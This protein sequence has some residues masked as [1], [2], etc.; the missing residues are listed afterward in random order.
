MDLSRRCSNW[1]GRS[2]PVSPSVMNIEGMLA[3]FDVEGLVLWPFCGV[4]YP[5]LGVHLLDLCLSSNSL[6]RKGV[7]KPGILIQK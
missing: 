6:E 3:F 4:K 7:Q 5:L 2:K 1:F